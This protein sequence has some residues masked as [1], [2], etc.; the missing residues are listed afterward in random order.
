MT[1]QSC[2]SQSTFRNPGRPPSGGPRCWCPSEASAPS[3]RPSHTWGVKEQQHC[4]IKSG[5]WQFFGTNAQHNTA[6]GQ[7]CLCPTGA[8]AAPVAGLVSAA[9]VGEAGAD[10]HVFVDASAQAVD[11]RRHLA[12]RLRQ[13]QNQLQ[14][15]G[16]ISGMIPP[17]V[18]LVVLQ[19]RNTNREYWW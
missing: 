11:V 6:V 8:A 10:E 12:S 13:R 17:V 2:A 16:A 15:L 1:H 5:G 19:Q 4:R 9:D 3:R 18:L 14:G 7:R